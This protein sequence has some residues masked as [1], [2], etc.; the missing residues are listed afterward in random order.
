MKEFITYFLKLLRRLNL[1]CVF[2]FNLSKTVNGVIFK[3]P[4]IRGIGINNYVI[5]SDWLDSIIL[6]F[7]KN[8]PNDTF[9]DVGTN[10]G[11]TLIKARSLKPNISYIGFE[12]NPICYAYLKEL[13]KVNKFHNIRILNC[14]LSFSAQVLKLEKILPDDVR[15][16]IISHL[17][18]GFSKDEDLVVTIDYDTWFL[19]EHIS[20]IKIDVE[21]SEME[22][23]RGMKQSITKHQPIIVCEVLDIHHPSVA[24]YAQARATELT[25]FLSSL[26]YGIIRF[27]TCSTNHK[28]RYIEKIDTISLVQWTQNSLYMNDYLFYPYSREEEIMENLISICS[29]KRI[30]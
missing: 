25:R 30:E 19:N 4:F 29:P 1:L 12:P 3:I 26:N 6:K 24:E 27:R 21:G 7:I 18:P 8:D 22:V 10:I 5:N 9:I 15:A 23:L 28:I 11:Q 16:S 20:F 14:A 13:I 17:R 2:N